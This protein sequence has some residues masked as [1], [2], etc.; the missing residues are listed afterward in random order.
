MESKEEKA[1]D[2]ENNEKINFKICIATGVEFNITANSKDIFREVLNKFLKSH[3]KKELESMN[4]GICNG[5]IVD[6]DKNLEE[7]N[8]KENTSV[9]LY[10]LKKDFKSNPDDLDEKEKEE[11]EIIVDEKLL[12]ELIMNEFINFQ[13]VLMDNINLNSNNEKNKENEN[14]DEKCNS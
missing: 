7:N 12:E 6:F 10:D 4:T 11:K 13:N 8:I 14:K 9:I 3:N 1:S 5:G 2:T